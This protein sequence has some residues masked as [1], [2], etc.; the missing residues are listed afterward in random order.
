MIIRLRKEHFK[1]SI[2]RLVSENNPVPIM[3][4]ETVVSMEWVRHVSLYTGDDSIFKKWS[5]LYMWDGIPVCR[6]MELLTFNHFSRFHFEKKKWKFLSTKHLNYPICLDFCEYYPNGNFNSIRSVQ[7]IYDG[8]HSQFDNWE[9][10][11]WSKIPFTD[12]DV[13]IC[14]YIE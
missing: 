14:Y 12:V 1:D 11:G 8:N 6:K 3:F 10:V 7:M 9:F 5:V 13:P 4:Y 2:H